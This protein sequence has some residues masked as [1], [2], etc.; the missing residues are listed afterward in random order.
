MIAVLHNLINIV[1]KTKPPDSKVRLLDVAC[2]DMIWMSRF[3]E[4][5][6]D[7]DF[8]GFDIVPEII[9]HHVQKFSNRP[10]KFYLEDIVQRKQ[11][12]SYDI[13]VARMIFQHLYDKDV[14]K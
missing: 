2:G 12:A 8:T 3:L 14:L 11:I 10:W 9:K 1:K 4:T 7:V 6:D 5:R 13:I